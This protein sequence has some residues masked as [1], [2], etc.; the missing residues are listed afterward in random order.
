[1]SKAQEHLQAIKET[2][3]SGLD[4]HINADDTTARSCFR[5]IIARCERALEESGADEHDPVANPSAAM[6]AQTSAGNTPRSYTPEAIRQRDMRAGIEA[7]AA[8]RRKL[9]EKYR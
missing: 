2:A 3:K 1:M 9:A 5:N 4:A 6:G 7:A 8:F